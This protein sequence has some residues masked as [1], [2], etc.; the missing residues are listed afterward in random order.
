M[1]RL[2]LPEQ[3]Y[4][5]RGRRWMDCIGRVVTRSSER[6]IASQIRDSWNSLQNSRATLEFT[7]RVLE[8]ADFCLLCIP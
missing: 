3:E 8:R 6:E 4:D 2:I 5:V 7:R 1:P